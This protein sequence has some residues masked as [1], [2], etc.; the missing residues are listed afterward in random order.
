[1]K[2]FDI[3]RFL[4]P[5]LSPTN[6]KIHL[7]RNN[8]HDAPIDVFIEGKFD[9][10]QT[11]QNQRNFTKEFVLS[12]V[13]TKETKTWLFVGLFSVRGCQLIE[14]PSRHF[15][16]DLE[17]INTCEE[18]VGKLYATTE[19]SARQSYPN[20][21]TLE[22]DLEISHISPRQLS[23][24]EFPGYKLVDI[25]K[26]QLNI[27]VRDN[28]P[29]W[30][31]ALSNV[32]GIYLI[33]D[34][35]QHKLYVGKADGAEGIWGR[36]CIYAKNGHGGNVALKE[37]IGLDSIARQNDLRFS[38]LEI[39]DI[40]STQDEVLMRESHWKRILMTRDSGYNRN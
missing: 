35:K 18:L 31:T 26:E 13:Q 19:Y 12:F 9:E 25:S 27:I 23:I 36:W 3:L 17:R 2:A 38:L 40:H 30:R 8:N 24:E 20:G 29:S 39:A 22:H 16:Y 21:S 32:K 4:E 15:K 14:Q 5:K 37:E 7:A 28:P 33:S 10:W 1:M 34:T 6:C 11:W